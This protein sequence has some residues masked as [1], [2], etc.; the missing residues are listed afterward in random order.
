MNCN[1]CVFWSF[2]YADDWK[3]F[4]ICNSTDVK[5][6]IKLADDLIFTEALF[7][8]VWY[9]DMPYVVAKIDLPNL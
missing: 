6:Q 9:Q 8:C 2:G 1:T 7:G 3:R 4:G 5:E